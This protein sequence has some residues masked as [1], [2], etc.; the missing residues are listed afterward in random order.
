VKANAEKIPSFIEPMKAL[1]VTDLPVDDWLYELQFDG[2]R[3]LAFKAGKEVRLTSRNRTNYD[4][5]YPLLTDALKSLGAKK[6]TIDGE[7]AALDDQDR[8]SFQ[9][10]QSY[11][12]AKTDPDRLLRL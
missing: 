3:A 9:L 10:L 8:S 11:G 4:N 5:D 2:Y 6:A 1:P 7:I 12:K